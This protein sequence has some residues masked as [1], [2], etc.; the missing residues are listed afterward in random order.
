[1]ERRKFIAILGG[2]AIWPVAARAQTPGRT[3]R[4]GYLTFSSSRQSSFYALLD[5]LRL[6]GFI[7]GQNLTVLDDGFGIVENE[8]AAAAAA[9]VKASP[10]AIFASGFVLA[11]AVQSPTKAIPI[12]VLSE[13]LL[14][15]GLTSSLARPD[16]NITGTPEL[17]GKRQDLMIEAV[18]GGRRMAT[19]ADANTTAPQQLKTL[20]DAASARGIELAIFT[21]RTPEDIVPAM[22][23][24]KASGAAAINVLASP[25]LFA[26]RRLIIERTRE[27]RL[28][29]V[30][31]FPDLAEQGGLIG[32]GP[33]FTDLYHLLGRQLVKILRGTSPADIPIEQPSRFELVVNL[34]TAKEIGLEIPANFVLRADKLI[35]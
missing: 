9:L 7:E 8:L 28:P 21:I 25:L 27:L 35:E 14:A 2:S 30:Y 20:R 16:R 1:M 31:A 5:E 4:I 19:L 17:A 24:I 3:Y 15:E 32:Y 26:N 13:D 18:P 11:K 33:R 22:D 6:A 10:D 12:L 29:A 34:K 23:E